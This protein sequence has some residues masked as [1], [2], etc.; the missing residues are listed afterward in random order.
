MDRRAGV[1]AI[2]ALGIAAGLFSLHVARSD[3]TF[4]FA[5]AS[6]AAGVA[7]IL[8]GWALMACGLAFRLGRPGSRFG[9][10]LAAA[11]L[12]W[13]VSEWGNP[14]GG[15]AL[16][17]T[18][19]LCFYAACPPIV[20]YAVLAFPGGRLAGSVERGAVAI[21]YAGGVL[22][23]G[24]LPAMLAG[25][26]AEGCNE[27]PRNLVAVADN[28]RRVDDLTRASLYVGFA[29]AAALA[30]LMIATLVRAGGARRPIL[31]AGGVYTAL[32]AAT[33]AASFDRGVLWNG[34][35]ERR[36]WWGEAA[37][38]LAVAAAVAWSWYR[39]RRARSTVAR[40]VVDLAQSPPAGGLR[41]VLAGIVGDPR[42]TV[43]YPVDGA[44][45]LLDADGR[46]VEPTPG[47]TR[48]TLV[49]GTRPVAVLEHAPGVLTD[50]QLLQEVSAAAQLAIENERLQAEVR[51][52]LDELRA[53]RAR[54]VEAGDAERKRLERDLHDGAQQRLVGLSLSLRLARTRLETE[55]DATAARHLDEADLELREAIADLRELAHGIFPVALADEGLAAAL[56]A[57]A[58]D[59]Q[60]PV[61]LVD[62]PEERYL[63]AVE[64]A[65]Y[66]VAAEVTRCATTVVD[67]RAEH[68]NGEL[69][70]DVRTRMPD[71]V[72]MLALEDRVGALDGRL[73][74]SRDR[75]D[76]TTIRAE[77]PCA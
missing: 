2:S 38:L 22:M 65:A 44:G 53:S 33:F 57:L 3:P 73:V 72:D 58:E 6:V 24:V 12:A 51:S 19:G 63:P 50:E 77:L 26:S 68:A 11:G 43:A 71:D 36:L 25:S 75:G 67:V 55:L 9:L 5:G 56:E 42:L 17:F 76:E 45:R 49:R 64:S 14:G 23:L 35:L 41:D 8:T 48:T 28:A 61:R 20:G 74:V 27:C 52:R 70:I 69:V 32:V 39:A 37:S 4:S 34:T 7:F 10:L 18:I 15:S 54:I 29:W 1:A 59:A 62:V 21:A 66:A 13:F 30:L 40:L 60:V 46:V 16:V 47:L 31:A